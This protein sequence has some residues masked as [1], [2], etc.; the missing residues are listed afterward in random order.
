[1]NIKVVIPCHLDSIRLEQKVLINIQG[2]PMVEHVRR[3][4]LL[5]KKVDNVFVATGDKK[6]KNIIESYGGKV[7]FTKNIHQNGTSR[8]AESI[9]QIDCTH[10]L[11]IQGDEPL[12]IPD[13]LD[14]FIENILDSKEHLMWNA[15]SKID[16]KKAYND[17]SIVKCLINNKA[18]IISCF[19]KSPISNLDANYSN[20]IFKIQGLIA[21][22]KTFLMNLVKNEN[23]L[24]SKIESIEQMKAIE[25]GTSIKSILLPSSLPSVNTKSELD[26]VCKILSKNSIQQNI[27][28]KINY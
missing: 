7:L 8:A 13:Y 18:E 15:I 25:T 6:I 3:R 28:N 24:F 5:S 14:I 1:M 27:F 4:A 9:S 17:I 22:E 2:L 19:R 10:V 20:L 26:Q 21:Y 23:T 12:L 11:L 16:S